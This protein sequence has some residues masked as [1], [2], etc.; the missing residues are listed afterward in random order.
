MVHALYY[1]S[2]FAN[3]ELYLGSLRNLFRSGLNLREGKA[4]LPDSRAF[5]AH[6][7]ALS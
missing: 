5:S 2:A 1:K 6:R 7:N 3:S 4:I